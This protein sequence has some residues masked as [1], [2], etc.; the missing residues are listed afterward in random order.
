V[1]LQL[2]V[3]GPGP[4]T[5]EQVRRVDWKCRTWIWRTWNW[6]TKCPGMKLRDMKLKDRILYRLKI[7]YI[8]YNAVSNSIYNNGKT[9]VTTAK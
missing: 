8:I 5:V 6:W 9:Q 7:N 4:P 2:S 1:P 3:G